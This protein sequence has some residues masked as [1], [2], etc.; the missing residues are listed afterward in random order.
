[1]KYYYHKGKGRVIMDCDV[2]GD[3]HLADLVEMG[4]CGEWTIP[5]MAA[6]MGT[7]PL[8]YGLETGDVCDG[9]TLGLMAEREAMMRI[10]DMFEDMAGMTG[11]GSQ[12]S[13]EACIRSVHGTLCA[14]KQGQLMELALRIGVGRKPKTSI[15]QLKVSASPDMGHMERTF[16]SLVD[17]L[18]QSGAA[19]DRLRGLVAAYVDSYP[20]GY[21]EGMAKLFTQK[22]N[23]GVGAKLVNAALGK[24]LIPDTF[25]MKAKTDPAIVQKWLTDGEAVW[26]EI[27]EDGIR[28]TAEIEAGKGVTGIRTYNMSPLDITKMTHIVPQ[29]NTLHAQQPAGFMGGHYFVDFEIVGGLRQGISGEVGQ[30]IKGTAGE[31]CDKEWEARLF[32][33]EEWG[34]WGKKKGDTLY[35][36][37]RANL[38]GFVHSAPRDSPCLQ[39]SMVG[40]YRVG[41]FADVMGLFAEV[42][43]Q[44]HEGLVLKK[45][46]GVYEMKRSANWVKMKAEK[47]C[48]LEITGWYPGEPGTARAHFGGFTCQSSDGRVKVN[49]GTGFGDKFLA[50]VR[51]KG[52]D[53]YVGKI[54]KVLYNT[55]V[56]KKGSSTVSLFLP[57]FGG[58]REDKDV[59][60]D[61]AYISK[62]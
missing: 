33:I 48:D 4:P 2:L 44:G 25:A 55:T 1:M 3:H 18:V 24:V 49:P 61:Y 6:L 62:K 11:P 23:A 47:E 19:T 57:R 37:R 54:A 21:R 43:G 35:C 9:Y 28:A 29:L 51:E 15:K 5:E 40:R 12:V 42:L 20:P 17:E 46:S 30:L 10:L 52:G 60:N 58:I 14:A 45:G 41:S 13:K 31:G 59:A 38:H 34:A 56:S 50:E 36:K 26:A 7:C 27:K 8:T 39:V 16:Q 22:A 32:D 53:W